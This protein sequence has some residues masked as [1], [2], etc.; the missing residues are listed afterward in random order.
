MNCKSPFAKGRDKPVRGMFSLTKTLVRNI[1]RRR[2][3]HH[4]ISFGIRTLTTE[5]TLPLR[6]S[7]L[8]VPC[9]SERKL[10]K[11]LQ[12]ES[13]VVIYDLE[14]S[15]SPAPEA[16]AAAR[17]R[18]KGFMLVCSFTTIDLNYFTVI[19]GQ[20]EKLGIAAHCRQSER[21]NNTF[22]PR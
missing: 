9:S 5:T 3:S 2:S 18:L 13:D 8:Y 16:K 10:Q 6:R 4:K 11:S 12:T 1:C 15:I 17:M 19:S 7:Y 14:D 22:F 20:C 21:P